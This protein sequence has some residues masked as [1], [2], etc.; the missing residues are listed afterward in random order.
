M[1]LTA[2]DVIGHE[3]PNCSW[4]IPDELLREATADT[5]ELYDILEELG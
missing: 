3:S 4:K 5:P 1:R 2:S